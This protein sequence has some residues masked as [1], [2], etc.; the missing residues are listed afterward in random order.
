[1]GKEGEQEREKTARGR[2][3]PSKILS[4]RK[5]GKGR[6]GAPKKGR[7][8]LSRGSSHLPSIYSA[9]VKGIHLGAEKGEKTLP[10]WQK[11]GGNGRL[12]VDHHAG[13]E[14]F[15]KLSHD[16]AN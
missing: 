1:L 15:H 4:R 11:Q 13:E 2:I 5:R 9:R 6:K 14:R 10:F 12:S 3:P 8:R 7:N 16:L